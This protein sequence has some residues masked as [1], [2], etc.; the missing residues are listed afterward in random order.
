M[1]TRVL[2]FPRAL[3][4][5]NAITF[6]AVVPL[7]FF[8][9]G[10]S[11]MGH[12]LS[13]ALVVSPCPA[14][15]LFAVGGALA[16]HRPFSQRTTSPH[17]PF[18]GATL[19]E[20]LA[21]TVLTLVELSRFGHSPPAAQRP[22]TAGDD[23]AFGWSEVRAW[24]G[25]GAFAAAAVYGAVLVRRRSASTSI[26]HP[27]LSDRRSPWFPTAVNPGAPANDP[28]SYSV[29][30]AG[31]RVSVALCAVRRMRLR[32]LGFTPQSRNPH[33]GGMV[34]RVLRGM[35]QAGPAECNADLVDDLALFNARRT[36]VRDKARGASGDDR[37]GSVTSAAPVRP[38][39]P[40]KRQFLDK[41]ADASGRRPN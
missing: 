27:V 40:L 12:T 16:R 14:L 7:M 19:A 17:R 11:A 18:H 26:R 38:T 6:P 36:G 10:A 30:L 22:T 21:A 24:L 1:I 25:P 13:R 4:Q 9:M 20:R 35:P 3:R 32:S 41:G 34:A 37:L 23:A 33:G 15:L 29:P 5:E 28:A 8:C 31:V 2:C 39:Q